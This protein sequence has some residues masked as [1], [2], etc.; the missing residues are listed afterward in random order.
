MIKKIVFENKLII[1]ILVLAFALRLIAVKPGYPIP[2]PD[3]STVVGGA[4]GM[5]YEGH[6][7]PRHYGY[8]SLA[9][10]VHYLGLLPFVAAKLLVIDWHQ[11]TKLFHIADPTLLKQILGPFD[12][13]ATT[14]ARGMNTLLA[15]TTIYLTFLIAKKLFG[16]RTA[17]LAALLFT[18]S[19]R[20]FLSSIIALTDIPNLFFSLLSFYLILRLKEK[21]EWRDYV[22]AGF[23]MAFTFSTKYQVFVYVPFMLLHLLRAW[24]N[25]DLRKIFNVKVLVAMLILPFVF[26]CLN[27]FLFLNWELAQKQIA[28]V[29]ERYEAGILSLNLFPLS[30]LFHLGM[31]EVVSALAILGMIISAKQKGEDFLL[32]L[33]YIF[34]VWF[35]VSIYTSAGP[36]T[37]WTLPML[38]FLL[39][40]ATFAI[41]KIVKLF[42]KNLQLTLVC[43][44][45][46]FAAYVPTK[47]VMALIKDYRKPWNFLQLKDWVSKNIPE[48][49]TL[50]VHGTA[51][52]YLPKD[53]QFN[54]IKTQGR[55]AYFDLQILQEQKVD[56]AIISFEY[57]ELNFFWWMY[58]PYG[59]QLEYLRVPVEELK[60]S[61]PAQKVYELL[62]YTVVEFKK[63]WQTPEHNFVVTKIPPA[64]QNSEQVVNYIPST[65]SDRDMFYKFIF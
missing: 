41:D 12:S 20:H 29:A 49:S 60:Q 5:F 65:I 35:V 2:H 24:K 64:G 6:L 7:D 14:W 30:Y 3:E 39:M 51:D 53:K 38:P 18:L 63:S 1:A 50:A 42:K 61:E 25:K 48:Q 27:P 13:D 31:G 33:S 44:L 26:V 46:I 59:R 9:P 40:F 8:P 21:Q 54:L 11:I 19:Y 62:P 45:I 55:E 34:P 22:F 10:Y 32:I 58:A 4:I 15:V 36:Y 17:F 43:M 52:Y 23:A 47:N 28:G 37:R 56:Y 57:L 16:K